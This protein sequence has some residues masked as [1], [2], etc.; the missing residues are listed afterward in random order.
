MIAS[1]AKQAVTL[2]PNQFIYA[3]HA[4]AEE[5]LT[6]LAIQAKETPI[7]VLALEE[8]E[9]CRRRA[10]AKVIKDQRQ[11][12][13]LM[14]Q[15]SGWCVVTEKGP[16][17][18]SLHARHELDLLRDHLESGHKVVLTVG[19][20]ANPRVPMTSNNHVSEVKVEDSC[21]LPFEKLVV[22]TAQAK[23]HAIS[24]LLP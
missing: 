7:T 24:R 12:A 6:T 9:R 1:F 4:R 17:K 11:Y 22:L 15:P 18:R 13:D 5:T 20:I 19:I 8:A 23:V 2:I 21:N 16:W 14:G 3:P 10:C